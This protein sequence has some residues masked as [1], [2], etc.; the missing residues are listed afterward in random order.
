MFQHILLA[1]DLEAKDSW[2]KSV[3]EAVNYAKAFGATLHVIT[4]V[5][6][7]GM[8]IVGS[9]FPKEHE[10]KMLED[11]AKRLHEFVD[12]NIPKEVK[13]QVVVGHGSA[14]EEILAMQ[15]R[16]KCDLIIMSAHR[17][18]MQDYL[19]GPN[20]ARVVRHANCSVLVVR[21]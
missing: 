15:R 17:P 4:V 5:P 16:L 10:G 14:Y 19:L 12:S 18:K 2:S 11:A 3:P 13:S 1:V 20:A 21:D 9:F 7:F 8:S 6:D